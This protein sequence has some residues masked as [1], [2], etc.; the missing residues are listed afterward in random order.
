M[1]R[2]NIASCN[3][4]GNRCPSQTLSQVNLC[5]LPSSP[6]KRV[7]WLCNHT[8]VEINRVLWVVI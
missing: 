4:F 3:I 2:I 5:Y 6:L 8:R 1:V 7:I